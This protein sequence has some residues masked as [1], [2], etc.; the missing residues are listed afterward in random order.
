MSVIDQD[1]YFAEMAQIAEALGADPIPSSRT[2][3]RQLFGAVRPQL[4]SDERTREVAHIPC[5]RN[6]RRACW[7]SPCR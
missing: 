3:A 1:R 5:L 2:K 4:R 6:L 7:P